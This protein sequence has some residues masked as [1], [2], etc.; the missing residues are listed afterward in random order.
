MP[1]EC[2][3]IHIGYRSMVGFQCDCYHHEQMD[4]SGWDFDM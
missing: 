4:L 1:V 3:S 2:N